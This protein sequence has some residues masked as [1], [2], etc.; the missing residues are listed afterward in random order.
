MAPSK[1]LFLSEVFFVMLHSQ[2]LSDSLAFGQCLHLSRTVY[3]S[4][5]SSTLYFSWGRESCQTDEL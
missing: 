3:I 4:L 5:L 1:L 2:A